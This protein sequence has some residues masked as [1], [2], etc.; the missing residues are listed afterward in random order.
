MKKLTSLLIV[1]AMALCMVP[2]AFAYEVSDITVEGVGTYT[3]PLI[4]DSDVTIFEFIGGEIGVYTISTS[5]PGV[6]LHTASGSTFFVHGITEVEGNSAELTVKYGFENTPYL[7][8]VSGS[9][10]QAQIVITK[11]DEEV[12]LDPNTAPPVDYVP[13]HTPVPFKIPSNQTVTPLNIVGSN[14]ND[15]AVKG[16]DGYYHLN[17]A[18]G[19][20][21]YVDLNSTQY[22]SWRSVMDT[23]AVRATYFD[24]NGKFIE[25]L[26]FSNCLNTYLAAV[27]K[28]D[29]WYPLTDDLVKI[30]KDVGNQKGW[31]GP[32]S[33]FFAGYS[34]NPDSA[35]ML[36]CGYVTT[37]YKN[38]TVPTTVS[39][40]AQEAVAYET[41]ASAA[42]ELVVQGAGDFILT[43]N[44][45]QYAAV[46]GKVSAAVGS[47][48]VHF[49]ISN[50]T[51][52]AASY[53]IS[54][55]GSAHQ[56][57]YQKVVTV[58]TCEDQGY[59]T[60][61]CAC[62]DS[63][64]GD[65]VKANGH[66][67]VTVPGKAPT[68]TQP[69]LTDGK[70][71]SVCGLILVAQETIPATG[72]TVSGTVTSYNDAAAQVTV[73][74]IGSNGTV[75]YSTTVT[76]NSA[77]YRLT[78]VAA[79]TYTMQISKAGHATM[80]FQ[81]VVGAADVQKDVTIY[82]MGD[83][84][85]DGK[86]TATDYSRLLAHVKKTNTITDEYALLCADVT[87]DG[88]ITATDYSRLLAHVKK[89]SQLW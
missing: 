18:S 55:S 50:E 17:A 57:A 13:K 1:L 40:E 84:T 83:V 82:P 63:Y 69:G 73:E 5:S 14:K 74:L 60:Y 64:I 53:S 42:Q 48:T 75:A 32:D 25:K 56:H 52:A 9:A 38:I 81:L 76:G 29:G 87:G 49:V 77:A 3:V 66:T 59:T 4:N 34:I 10:A 43:V 24:E 22:F 65:Y 54:W 30:Y 89:V 61:T 6:Q 51:D 46:N 41:T 35:W 28:S 16:S 37:D 70:K 20:I 12:E 85:G 8:G 47:G 33:F 88:K 15:T 80:S 21:L 23:A 27:D 71:C 7:F 58:P 36:H 19:P 26:D 86:V 44:G 67:E 2:T 62:G 72:L 31:Y 79:G 39:H 45:R 11:S 78:K 68:G